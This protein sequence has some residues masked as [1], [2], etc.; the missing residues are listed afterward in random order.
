MKEVEDDD[1]A[2]MLMMEL[3]TVYVNN[4]GHYILPQ[5][6]YTYVVPLPTIP[7]MAPSQPSF[8]VGKTWLP[9]SQLHRSEGLSP[10]G[11]M[12]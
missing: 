1:A 9:A 8:M 12:A 10:G 3:M 4:R 2:Y 5:P 7:I 6:M 11:C